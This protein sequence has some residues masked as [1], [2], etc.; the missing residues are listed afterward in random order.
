MANIDE[1]LLAILVDRFY[2][3]VRVDPQLG[4]VFNPVVHDWSAHK[5]LLTS[6][7]SSV[8]I[9]TGAYRGNPMAMHR[10]HPI[11]AEHFSRWLEL[12]GETAREVLDEESAATMCTYAQHIGQGLQ[13]G[14]GL[15]HRPCNALAPGIPV[16]GQPRQ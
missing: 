4:A 11:R 15:L 3:K 13:L 16:V 7:W 2:D 10:P 8:A 5:R 9:R 1:P 12:W 6:F 14:L